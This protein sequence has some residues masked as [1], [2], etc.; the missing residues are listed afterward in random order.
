MKHKMAKQTHNLMIATLASSTTLILLVANMT[1]TMS[2]NHPNNLRVR[3]RSFSASS[4]S[5]QSDRAI[6]SSLMEQ[7]ESESWIGGQM[8]DVPTLIGSR[9]NFIIP[10]R[11]LFPTIPQDTGRNINV[12]VLSNIPL[13]EVIRAFRGSPETQFNERRLQRNNKLTFL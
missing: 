6:G 13:G 9:P 11:R 8:N 1:L 12:N 10:N 4:E 5:D 3:G 2:I 7:P